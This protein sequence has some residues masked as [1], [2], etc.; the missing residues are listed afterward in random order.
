[1]LDD[2]DAL[3]EG[4]GGLIV[5]LQGLGHGADDGHGLQ[6][7]LQQERLASLWPG[8]GEFFAAAGPGSDSVGGGGSAC[9]RPQG[10]EGPGTLSLEEGGGASARHQGSWVG[11]EPAA[12]G[13]RALQLSQEEGEGTEQNADHPNEAQVSNAAEAVAGSEVDSSVECAFGPGAME[14]GGRR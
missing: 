9:S 2:L 5:R 11:S 1:M 4:L 8:N 6:P 12:A 7:E 14:D 13:G 3:Q 10:Q